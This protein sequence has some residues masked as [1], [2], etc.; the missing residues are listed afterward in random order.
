MSKKL[1]EK[2]LFNF[3]H[4]LAVTSADKLDN[5]LINWKI[6]GLSER[7]QILLDFFWLLQIQRS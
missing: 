5:M 7:E 3:W 2:K 6:R 1:F 4:F